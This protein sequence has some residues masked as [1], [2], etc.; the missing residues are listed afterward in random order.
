MASVRTD[1]S[2]SSVCEQKSRQ[3]VQVMQRNRVSLVLYEKAFLIYLMSKLFVYLSL[4][5]PKS[6]LFPSSS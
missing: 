6:N 4:N 1:K 2:L 3:K 5:D